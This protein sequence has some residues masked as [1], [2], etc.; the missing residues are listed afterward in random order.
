MPEIQTVPTAPVS[1]SSEVQTITATGTP[2]AGTFR[3][4]YRNDITTPLNW[5]ATATQIRDA[6]RAL[7]EIQASGIA[8][9]T[10]GPVQTT[11]VVVNFGGHLANAN[12]AQLAVVQAAITGGGF[13]VTTGTPGV[14]GTLRGRPRG[15]VVV[16]ADTGK[17]YVNE[18]TDTAPIWKIVT[19]S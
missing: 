6:L 18:G 13:A 4:Q 9:A 11:P 10:G 17:L 3:L 19:T 12:V 14:T 2:T 15:T 16:T 5:N 8:S 1:G 7:N